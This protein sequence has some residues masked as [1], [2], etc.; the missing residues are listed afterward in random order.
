MTS[1]NSL[2]A[3]APAERDMARAA[4][5]FQGLMDHVVRLYCMGQT[6]SI[7]VH[8]LTELTRS[9]AYVLGISDATTE[10]AA[11]VLA[12]EDAIALWHDGLAALDARVDAALDVWREIVATMPPIPNV[13]LR[14]TLASLG[15]LKTRYDAYFAAHVVPADIDYQLSKPQDPGLLGLDYIEAWLAQLLEETRWLARFETQSLLSALRRTCPDPF[16]LHVNLYDLLLPHEQEL[17]M[18]KR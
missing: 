8:E 15:E 10:E 1:R 4:Q 13:S 12:C 3:G 16:G 5:A 9:V 17:K 18:R 2:A 7:S 14:E 6:S 11:V